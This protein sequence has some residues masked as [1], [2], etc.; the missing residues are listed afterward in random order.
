MR[1]FRNLLEESFLDQEDHEF[2]NV[3]EHHKLILEIKE[4]ERERDKTV[5]ISFQSTVYLNKI[6]RWKS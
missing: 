3:Y 2:E 4:T 1:N 5:Q 6:R